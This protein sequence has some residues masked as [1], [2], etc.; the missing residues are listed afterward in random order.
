[1]PRRG[2][3]RVEYLTLL[4]SGGSQS[5]VPVKHHPRLEDDVRLGQTADS[6]E[7]FILLAEVG[8]GELAGDGSPQKVQFGFIVFLATMHAHLNRFG[9]AGR[10]HIELDPMNRNPNVALFGDGCRIRG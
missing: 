10:I 5:T 3:F 6:L 7:K 8:P 9:R 4:P 2:T 1:M